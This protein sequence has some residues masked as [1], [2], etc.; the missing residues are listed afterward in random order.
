MLYLILKTTQDALVHSIGK[1][2]DF[3]LLV[4]HIYIMKKEIIQTFST[5]ENPY[6]KILD[7]AII[8]WEHEDDVYV[9]KIMENVRDTYMGNWGD[10]GSRNQ[11]MHHL[12]FIQYR[13]TDSNWLSHTTFIS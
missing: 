2:T 4:T 13:H 11:M 9:K 12:H 6:T 10:I 1:P 7:W 5:W 8:Y 3:M